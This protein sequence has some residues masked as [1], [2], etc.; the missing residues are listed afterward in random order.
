MKILFHKHQSKSKTKTLG[1]KGANILLTIADTMCFLQNSYIYD[2]FNLH[3]IEK[4][5]AYIEIRTEQNRNRLYAT[6]KL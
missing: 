2:K 5:H 1:L 4:Q 3:E 6:T